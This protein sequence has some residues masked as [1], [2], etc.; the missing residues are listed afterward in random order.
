MKNANPTVSDGTLRRK[1]G[2]Q[3]GDKYS[4]SAW[5]EACKSGVVAWDLC[6]EYAQRDVARPEG[7]PEPVT[8][9]EP[10]A[11]VVEPVTVTAPTDKID[12]GDDDDQPTPS[13]PEPIEG[14]RD[15]RRIRHVP[16]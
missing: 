13:T 3:I 6:P 8:Q 11:P 5:R 7:L 4:K 9:V 16:M 2:Q 12:L 10:V 15:C 14:R 1:A